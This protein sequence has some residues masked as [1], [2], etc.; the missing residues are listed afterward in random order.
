MDFSILGTLAVAQDDV[1]V[2]VRGPRQRALLALFL[3]HANQ[4]LTSDRI[5][6]LLWAGEPPRTAANTLQTHVVRLRQ[7]LRLNDDENGESRPL[8][9]IAAGYVLDVDPDAL[10]AARFETLLG[11]ARRA[12]ALE[13]PAV[14]HELLRHALALWRGPALV[15]F[16]SEP[17]ASVD[18]TR[19][20]EL[21]S[22]E[23]V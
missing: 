22:E 7:A 17:F 5:V 19:L 13:R 9:T 20:D 4:V 21:R 12:I 15:E 1:P 16:A 14:A 23:R 2:E 3:L 6:D 10:D 8:R 11:E 18:A